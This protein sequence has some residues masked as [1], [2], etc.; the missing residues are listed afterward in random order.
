MGFLAAFAAPKWCP[1][2]VEG[3]CS[4]LQAARARSARTADRARSPTVEVVKPSASGS[5]AGLELA[6][7]PADLPLTIEETGRERVR[8]TQ[9]LLSGRCGDPRVV[10]H[11]I[12]Q[13]LR[14]AERAPDPRRRRRGHD[15]KLALG[16]PGIR[17]NENGTD[18]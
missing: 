7:G 14:Q 2:V 16:M 17:V 6:L 10:D 9:H 15:Q 5:G 4:P 13:Q 3:S 1:C 8:A 12:G 11:E 18:V